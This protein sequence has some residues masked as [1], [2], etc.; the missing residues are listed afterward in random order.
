VLRGIEELDIDETATAL[1]TSRNA[2]EIRL[3]RARQALKTMLERLD[4]RAH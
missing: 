4:A 3:H 2:V 1:G